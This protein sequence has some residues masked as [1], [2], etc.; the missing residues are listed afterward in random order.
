MRSRPIENQVAWDELLLTLADQNSGA[1]VHVLQSWTWGEV[2]PRWGWQVE[3]LAFEVD[4][5]PVASAQLMW[6]RIGRSPIRIGYVPKGPFVPSFD[7]EMWSPVLD[8]IERW[9]VSR[10]LAFVK[11]DADVPADATELLAARQARGWHP[12]DNQ[13]QFRNTMRSDL[14]PGSDAL[15][16]AFHAKTRY[17]IRLAERHGVVV[18]SAGHA[19]IE[20]ALRLYQETARRQGFAIRAPEYYRDVWTSWLEASLAEILVAELNGE[21]LAAAV[22]TR[23]G[24]TAWYLYGASSDRMREAMA[25]HAV[26]WAALSW[27]IQGGCETFDWWGGPDSLEPS[28]PM[29]GVYRFKH[30]FGARFEV[31]SGAWDFPSNSVAYT[32]FRAASSLRSLTRRSRR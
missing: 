32:L 16:G 14:K 5:R 27:A 10:R 2:K 23:F 22:P 15:F 19:G 30:G 6:R 1:P 20:P 13:I 8:A 25:P 17:N 12:S 21:A 29:W 9:A 31:Q 28:D 11:I 3:R 26:M 18:R 7:P 4:D 24:N